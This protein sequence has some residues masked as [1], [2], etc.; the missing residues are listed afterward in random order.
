MLVPNVRDHINPTQ[1]EFDRLF[2]EAGGI[3]RM[4]DSSGATH[5]TESNL[6]TVNNNVFMARS[7]AFKYFKNG[8]VLIVAKR[9]DPS[10]YF[11][12]TRMDGETTFKFSV[13]HTMEVKGF[14]KEVKEACRLLPAT[15]AVAREIAGHTAQNLAAL[16]E[17]IDENIRQMQNQILMGT[18]N[19]SAL[20]NGLLQVK[21]NLSAHV[22]TVAIVGIAA[23]FVLYAAYDMQNRTM[24]KMLDEQKT[25]KTTVG[26]LVTDV[27]TLVTAYK[28]VNTRLQKLESEYLTGPPRIESPM[29]AQTYN[30]KKQQIG[31]DNT[32]GVAKKE[33]GVFGWISDRFHEIMCLLFCGGALWVCRGL[34]LCTQVYLKA[35]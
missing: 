12:F 15:N 21:S 17:H 1:E 3:I 16:Q 32:D 5:V 29:D 23:A 19:M 24:L 10:A 6:N 31:G 34:Y 2:D 20:S 25:L 28:D 30:N 7:C 18:E 27:T 26:H 8:T 4:F 11:L 35:K 22:W 9:D 14:A 33:G 13:R